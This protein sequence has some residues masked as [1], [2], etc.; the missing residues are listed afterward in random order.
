MDCSTRRDL[1]LSSLDERTGDRDRRLKGR[2]ERLLRGEGL[3]LRDL[4]GEGL[5]ESGGECRR[6]GEGDLTRLEPRLRLLSR[7]TVCLCGLSREPAA[8]LLARSTRLLGGDLAGLRARLV[9]LAGEVDRLRGRC[10]SG[11]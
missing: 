11:L 6:R 9:L 10:E 7:C 2:G 1:A 8:G 5:L 4:G 3:V